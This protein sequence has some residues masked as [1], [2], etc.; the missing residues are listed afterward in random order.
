M[1]RNAAAAYK[2]PAEQTAAAGQAIEEGARDGDTGAIED[3]SGADDGE[4]VSA[5]ESADDG[6]SE[7]NLHLAEAIV[8]ALALAAGGLAFFAWRRSAA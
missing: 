2:L 7:T 3:T 5:S 6:D 8:G 1:S 4:V